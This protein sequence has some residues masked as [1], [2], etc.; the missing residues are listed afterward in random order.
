MPVLMFL[1][2]LVLVGVVGGV[3]ALLASASGSSPATPPGNVATSPSGLVALMNM[4]PIMGAPSVVVAELR[5]TVAAERLAAARIVVA[6]FRR[7]GHSEG[8]VLAAL[9]NGWAESR[10]N[11]LAHSKPPEDSVGF[12]QLN[13]AKNAA[14]A[15]MTAAQREDPLRNATRILEV[16][17]GGSGAALRA[18]QDQRQSVADLTEIFARDIERCWECGHAGGSAQLLARRA[19]VADLFGP[20]IHGAAANAV[21]VPVVL[22]GA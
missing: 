10:W 18:A 5:P 11:P 1:G 6:A 17:A 12:F 16:I 15:G 8:L 4:G 2:G 13:S 3:A 20:A 9:V 7:A 14:G 19:M 22:E 21:R